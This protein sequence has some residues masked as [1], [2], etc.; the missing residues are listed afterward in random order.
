LG[1][2]EADLIGIDNF[3]FSISMEMPGLLY[4]I[5]GGVFLLR[6]FSTANTNSWALEPSLLLPNDPEIFKFI[7]EFP[8]FKGVLGPE[9]GLVM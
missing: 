6:I 9:F 3:G 7:Y 8:A 1:V 2:D 5:P 4:Y